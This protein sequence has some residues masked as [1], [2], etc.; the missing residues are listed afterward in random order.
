[1]DVRTVALYNYQLYFRYLGKVIQL[2]FS[3]LSLVWLRRDICQLFRLAQYSML[4]HYQEASES[5]CIYVM[6]FAILV[7]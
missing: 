2:T 5:I 1:M 6:L 3:A 7:S 4:V